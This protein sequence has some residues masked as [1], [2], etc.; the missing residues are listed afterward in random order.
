M[1]AMIEALALP[2]RAVAGGRRY[3]V[4]V[5]PAVLTA[6]LL[7]ELAQGERFWSEAQVF[8]ADTLFE[9]CCATPA[10]SRERFAALGLRPGQLH[11]DVADQSDPV[12]AAAAYEQQLRAVFALGPRDVPRFDAIVLRPGAL[13]ELPDET[14]RLAVVTWSPARRRRYVTLTPAVIH[15]AALVLGG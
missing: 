2:P 4:A 1:P 7:A 9:G 3:R 8:L 11:A 14:G 15:N 5:S 10:N 6:E 12:R 13:A